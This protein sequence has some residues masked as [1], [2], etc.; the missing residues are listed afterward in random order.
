M[1]YS[2]E[3]LEPFAMTGN[4][5]RPRRRKFT[6]EDRIYGVWAEHDSDDDGESSRYF[7]LGPI[8]PASKFL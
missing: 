5:F 1:E 6:K 4:E 7:S 8:C 2:D 3:E